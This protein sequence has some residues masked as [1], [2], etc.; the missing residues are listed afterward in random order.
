MG[1][2]SRLPPNPVDISALT[3]VGGEGAVVVPEQGSRY[4]ALQPLL[5]GWWGGGAIIIYNQFALLGCTLAGPLAREA[6]SLEYPKPRGVFELQLFH[7]ILSSV[8]RNLREFHTLP[9]LR[10]CNL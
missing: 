1:W 9:F 7:Y 6:G 8:V 3:L 2:Q 4:Q 5:W 10:S